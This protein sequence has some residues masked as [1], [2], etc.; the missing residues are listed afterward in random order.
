MGLVRGTKCPRP[1]ATG[2]LWRGTGLMRS[3]ENTLPSEEQRLC[4][5]YMQSGMKGRELV[6]LS[7]GRLK[8][9]WAYMEHHKPTNFVCLAYALSTIMLRQFP[10]YT[11]HQSF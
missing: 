10:T 8:S 11:T 2:C 9:H 4:F 7:N 3:K 5:G 1:S 6:N